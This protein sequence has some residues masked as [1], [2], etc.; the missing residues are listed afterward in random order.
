MYELLSGGS[1]EGAVGAEVLQPVGDFAAAVR[2]AQHHDAA[3]AFWPMPGNVYAGQQ[4]AHGMADEMNGAVDAIGK[5]LDG[6]M[7]VLRQRF[8]RLAAARIVQV[9][10]GESGAF[11]RRLHLSKRSRRPA[12]AMQQDDA[13]ST[14][15]PGISRSRVWC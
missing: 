10:G 7:N 2:C 4:P 6:G 8:Q 14:T 9:E 15:E 12:D 13:V 11:Q 1:E 5:A 3:Q